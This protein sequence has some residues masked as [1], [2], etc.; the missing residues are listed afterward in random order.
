MPSS[1]HYSLSSENRN[2]AT[3][4]I[5]NRRENLLQK[6]ENNHAVFEKPDGFVPSHIR[7][8]F[9]EAELRRRGI[10]TRRSTD[11]T[12]YVELEK[13]TAKFLEKSSISILSTVLQGGSGFCCNRKN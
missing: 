3:T 11:N 9:D 4:S 12:R 7:F 5:N 6:L 8:N 2:C 10:R 13:R 1:G